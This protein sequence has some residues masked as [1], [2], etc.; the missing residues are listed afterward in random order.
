MST[1]E[2]L[3]LIVSCTGE[4]SEN[5]FENTYKSVINQKDNPFTLSVIA[6][7]SQVMQ[8]KS[9]SC[10]VIESSHS[11][12]GDLSSS[13][14]LLSQSDD[15]CKASYVLLCSCGVVF[16]E[17]CFS[18]LRGNILSQYSHNDVLTA[19]GIRMFPHKPLGDPYHQ[20]RE[21]THWKLYDHSKTD[22]AI[23][24]FTPKLCLLTTQIL[25]EISSYSNSQF[26][27]LGHLWWSF[28]LGHFLR[29]SV[30]KVQVDAIVDFSHTPPPQFIPNE[31]DN[32]PNL[33]NDYYSHII[34]CNWP[35]S[36]SQPFHN[37]DN[38]LQTVLQN[39]KQ[40]HKI[41]EGGFGGVNM[42]AEP[43]TDLDFTAAAAYGIRVIRIGAVCDAKDL[44]F[45]I[46]PRASTIEEDKAHFLQSLPRLRSVIC[47]AAKNGLKVIITMTD[48]P[49]GMFHSHSHSE[50]LCSLSFW[51]SAYSRTRAV[52]FWGLVAESLA[53]LKTNIMGYDVINEPYTKEDMDVSFF[54]D[55]LL[56]HADKLNQFYMD[57]LREIRMHDSQTKVIIKSTWFSSP[58][59]IDI[60]Q[61]LPDPNVVYGFHMYAP[62]YLTLHRRFSTHTGTYPG[63]IPR[64]PNSAYPEVDTIEVSS[65]YLR[66]L[67]E[68]TVHSWQVKHAIPSNQILVA[69]F[70]IS[71]E[72]QGA[73]QYLED[74]ISLFQRFKWSW[75]LFS[76]RDEEWDA[77]DYELGPSTD[78]MLNRSPTKL[79]QTVANHFH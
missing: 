51:E 47:K 20:L 54:D 22:R 14:S 42:S 55:M 39:K 21:G 33:F 1:G 3:C 44:A 65:H 40:P 11:F 2:R 16:K 76:F 45:L 60:L 78:N 71:R 18:V 70:G 52:K 79:F 27:Q 43:A 62:H 5:A 32:M 29:Y 56:A 31:S 15:G 30:W 41:W 12:L 53:D 50:E 17:N 49:G 66:Q 7:R 61:P 34:G 38:L 77:L 59:T 48:L 9:S 68:S 28:V 75:L 8:V 4:D 57:V 73:Q 35:P 19:Q 24:V 67:L 37:A 26:S 6:W 72:V 36:I 23:H 13:L 63:H 46:D 25:R 69:E 58:R 74:L 10:H 64:W